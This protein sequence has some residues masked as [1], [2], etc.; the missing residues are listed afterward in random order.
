[1]L[2]AAKVEAGA[3]VAVF[4]CGAVGLAVIMGSQEAGASRIIAV[5]INP[6]KWEK[7]GEFPLTVVGSNWGVVCYVHPDG[8]M[9]ITSQCVGLN[10]CM[11]SWSSGKF[12][13]PHFSCSTRIW[14][15][16]VCEPS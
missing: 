3:S 2:N 4:G 10:G 7:G 9:C 14:S 13:M 5:D 15:N 6:D 1:M 11:Y 16:R 12:L 8:V